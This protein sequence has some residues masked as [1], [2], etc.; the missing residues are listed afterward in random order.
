VQLF[1]EVTVELR[2]PIVCHKA[3]DADFSGGFKSRAGQKAERNHPLA[4]VDQA[5]QWP[6]DPR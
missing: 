4:L 6:Q 3:H 2:W 1:A 5:E